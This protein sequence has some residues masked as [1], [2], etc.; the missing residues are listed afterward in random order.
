M[1]YEKVM[2]EE[3]EKIPPASIQEAS[4]PNP[5]LAGGPMR[6]ATPQAGVLQRLLRASLPEEEMQG[7]EVPEEEPEQGTETSG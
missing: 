1:G 2:A 6:S 7:E 4:R 3:K 5:Q